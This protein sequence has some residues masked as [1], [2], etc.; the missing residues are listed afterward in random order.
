MKSPVYFDLDDRSDS[1]ELGSDYFNQAGPVINQGNGG[2]NQAGTV[3]NQMGGGW[4]GN[5]AGTVIN[6]N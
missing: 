3:H 2:G 4:G 5:Q 1:D 6:Q